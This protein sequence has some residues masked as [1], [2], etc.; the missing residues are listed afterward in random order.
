LKNLIIGDFLKNDEIIKLIDFTLLKR[1]KT[2]EE[3]MKFL[4]KAKE[5]QPQAV[6]IFP[7]DIP[8]AKEILDSSISIAVVVG[9]FP[10]GS[11]NCEE[12]VEEIRMAIKLGADEIDIVLEP[13]EDDNYPNEIELEKLV[14]M[15]EAS[16]GKILK[17]I[18]ETPL[19]TERKIRAITRMSLAVG[20]D[21]VKTCT[22]KRGGCK[23]RDVDIL[24]YEL[25]RHEL[26]FKE[27]LGMKISG[28]I[29]EKH[30]LMRF[31]ELIRKNDSKIIDEKRL[32]VGS[33]SLIENLVTIE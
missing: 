5:Y 19:L 32:R 10:E 31:I 14:T 6:C 15:R 11:S 7:E 24:S 13:R 29:S 25:M 12:I 1:E 27:C 30:K 23:E 28:G 33:S 3:L 26:T 16:E 4:F 21:F 22:G 2:N 8:Y 20:I 18:I 17:V 9:G